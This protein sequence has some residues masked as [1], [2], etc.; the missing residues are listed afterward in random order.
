MWRDLIFHNEKFEQGVSK[1]L[2]MGM[3]INPRSN[4]IELREDA[5]AMAYNGNWLFFGNTTAHRDCFLWHSVMFDC[6]E[7][8]VPEFCRLR[9]YKVVVKTRNFHEAI[10]LY[11]AV[12]AGLASHAQLCV[13]H[14]KVGMDERW[15]TD[16]HFNGFVY[17]DGPIEA[18]E[19]YVYIRDIVDRHIDTKFAVAQGLPPTIPVIIKRSC[20]EFE[21]IHG[22]TDQPFWQAMTQEEINYQRHIEDIFK[23]DIGSFSQPDWLKNRLILKFVKWANIVGDKTWIDYFGGKDFLTMKAVTYHNQPAT[24]T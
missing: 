20:T 18:Q 10:Q 14:G 21:R 6:F 16:G 23:L 12:H 17:C 2:S 3:R 15:Y 4:Q 1:A 7:N 9:C 22:P 24:Q 5:K 8:F 11:N 19:K 13:I